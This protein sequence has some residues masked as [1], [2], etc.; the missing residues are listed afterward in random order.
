M[1]T[2]GYL[3][4]PIVMAKIGRRPQFITGIKISI[5]IWQIKWKLKFDFK[6]SK[7]EKEHNLQQ[8]PAD[9]TAG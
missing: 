6:N 1:T 3:I 4:S 9:N 2:L 5:I 7:V 8:P